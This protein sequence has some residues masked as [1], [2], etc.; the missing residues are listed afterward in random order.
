MKYF[1]V[2]FAALVYF[3]GDSFMQNRVRFILV[4]MGLLA[5]LGA[6]KKISS[7]ED[8]EKIEALEQKADV[9]REDLMKGEADTS[10]IGELG[11]AYIRFADQYPEAAETPEFLFRAGELYSNDLGQMEQ[12]VSIFKRNHQNYPN[13]ATAANAL[14]LIGYLY[15]NVLHNLP[16]AEKHYQLFLAE[17]P[18]HKMAQTASFELQFLGK[19]AEEVFRDI[20]Q[21]SDSISDAGIQ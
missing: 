3:L 16:E 7:R 19:S 12:A 8:L 20:V 1:L 2:I 10:V 13:H 9:E 18:Q 5:F 17:Y 6:C 15:H 14:F 4:L 11:R 21:P